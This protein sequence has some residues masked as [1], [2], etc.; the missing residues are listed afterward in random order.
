MSMWT[1]ALA[2]AVDLAQRNANTH[3]K[4]K[5]IFG[6]RRRTTVE[7]TTFV[8][9]KLAMNLVEYEHFGQRVLHLAVTWHAAKLSCYL[10]RGYFFGPLKNT[11]IKKI[12]MLNLYNFFRF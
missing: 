10:I 1:S 9:A 4:V 12:Y 6:D 3:E 7:V 11:L 5:G 2:H 8:E